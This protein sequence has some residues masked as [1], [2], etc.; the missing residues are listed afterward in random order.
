MSNSTNKS[1]NN[2]MINSITN[3]CRGTY[4]IAMRDFRAIVTSPLFFVV[5]GLCAV[6]WSLMYIQVLE[7]FSRRSLQMSFQ[8]RGQFQGL[9]LHFEAFVKHI[10]LVNFLMIM[11]I[12]AVT[13]RLF[14]EEKKLRTYD[15]LLTS[16]VSATEIA[17]G[18]FFA[19]YATATILVLISFIYPLTTSFMT[20]IQWGP[21]LGSYLG[22]WL[23]VGAYVAVG[24]FASSLTDSVMLAVVMGLIF[25]I[26]LWFVGTGEGLVESQVLKEVF[27]HLSVGQHFLDFIKGSVNTTGVVF[28]LSVIALNCF[29]TQRVV[30]SSRWR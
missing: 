25:N 2:S 29:L 5:A 6:V 14:S 17:L 30:E 18:K 27:Q 23:L 8:S 7:E 10:S 1:I 26:G 9:N 20:D 3:S 22:I 19:G 16:P 12:P 13:M 15:L 21:L 28:F 4:T 11:A 24:V